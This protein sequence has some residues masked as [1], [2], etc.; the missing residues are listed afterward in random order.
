MVV[1]GVSGVVVRVATEQIGFVTFARFVMQ[2]EIVL[3]KLNLPSGGV[4]SNLVG[5]RPVCEV[6]VISPNDDR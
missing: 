3:C 5:L 1:R 6:F 2:L 4:G